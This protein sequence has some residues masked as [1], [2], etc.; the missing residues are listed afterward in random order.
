LVAGA[1]AGIGMIGEPSIYLH[2]KSGRLY[3]VLCNANREAD[4]VLMVVYRNVATGDR[5]VRPADEFNDGRF[6]RVFA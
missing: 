4:G 6:E 5:W 3:E 1:F 2:K